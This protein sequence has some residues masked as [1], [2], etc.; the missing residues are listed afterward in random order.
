M[1][2]SGPSDQYYNHN[3]EVTSAVMRGTTYPSITYY[4]IQK[5]I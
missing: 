2:Q 4:I 3:K 5:V 1:S